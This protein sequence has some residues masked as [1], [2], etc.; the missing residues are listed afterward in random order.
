MVE[1]NSSLGAYVAL[2]L[3]RAANKTYNGVINLTGISHTTINITGL[4]YPNNDV[5]NL[6]TNTLLGEG[7][8]SFNIVLDTFLR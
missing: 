5:K 1:D 8:I 7:V 6:S 2:P 4:S 3:A